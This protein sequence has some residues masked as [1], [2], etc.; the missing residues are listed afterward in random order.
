MSDEVS[1][2][3]MPG[4]SVNDID[5]KQLNHFTGVSN[6]WVLGMIEPLA[7]ISL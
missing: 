2:M 1:M 6:Y 5:K 3:G 4:P 7:M